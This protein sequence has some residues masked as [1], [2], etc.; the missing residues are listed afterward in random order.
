MK[1]LTRFFTAVLAVLFIS[2][3]MTIA[4]AAVIT[5]GDNL[6]VE[7]IPPI[8]ATLAETVDRYTQFRSAGLLSWHS[9][10]R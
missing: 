8:P 5:P 2:G 9:T 10:L 4:Q 7:G 6:V 3:F 1:F